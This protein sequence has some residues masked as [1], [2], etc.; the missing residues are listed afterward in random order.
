VS[1]GN[2][3]RGE[4]E[5]RAYVRVVEG[6]ERHDTLDEERLGVLHVKVHEAHLS[7]EK[8]SVLSLG[9]DRQR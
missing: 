7:R 3:S 9:K 8:A 5:G 6:L 1:R 2:R 4:R